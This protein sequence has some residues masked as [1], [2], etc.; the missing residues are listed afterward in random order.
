MCKRGGYLM[1]M[2]LL[3]ALASGEALPHQKPQQQQ[4]SPQRI[5]SDGQHLGNGAYAQRTNR[6]KFSFVFVAHV[7]RLWPD[8]AHQLRRAAA[9]AR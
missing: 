3:L 7:H 1:R 2:L 8:N 6:N 9:G 4:Q 5:G